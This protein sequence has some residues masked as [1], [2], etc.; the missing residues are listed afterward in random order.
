MKDILEYLSK[1]GESHDTRIAEATGNTLASTRI[2]LAEL[3]AQN[4]IMV[5]HSTRFEKGKKI[6]GINCRITGFIPKAKPGAKSKA[7]L[8]LS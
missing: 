6:E 3:A 4:E 2:K 5:C 7:Q 8:K 1:H